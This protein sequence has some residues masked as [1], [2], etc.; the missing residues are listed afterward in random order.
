MNISL[1]EKGVGLVLYES[2][3][4]TMRK[5]IEINVNESFV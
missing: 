2:G 3:H 1:W 5:R 4:G